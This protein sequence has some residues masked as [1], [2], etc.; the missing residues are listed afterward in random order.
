[1]NGFFISGTDTDVGKTLI[2]AAL[3]AA[4]PEN[5]RYWK[6]I[7]TG[8]PEHCDTATVLK[9]S[10]KSAESVLDEGLRFKEPASPHYAARLEKTDIT[11]DSLT[12]ISKRDELQTS[13][14]V[15]E[16]AGGLLVPLNSKLLMT[17]LIRMLKLSVILVS[18]TRLGT[19]N[20]TLLSAYHLSAMG[21]DVAGIVLSGERDESAVTGIT[22]HSPCPIIAEVPFIETLDPTTL[23]SVGYSL[24]AHPSIKK[25]IS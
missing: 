4:A 1:M 13:Q 6:P 9:L 3:M 24:W 11:L 17:D 8:F 14:W 21:V 5:V 18:S 2:S 12:Q 7:Q 25:R 22:E 16:G 15:V 10:G 23:K 19:I 20:H